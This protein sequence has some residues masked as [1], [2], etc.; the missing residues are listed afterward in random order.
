MDAVIARVNRTS[1]LWQLFAS[2]GDLIVVSRDGRAH[3]Y[4]EVPVDYIH[5]SEFG[6]EESYF[7]ITLEYGPDH[8][9]HDPFDVSVGR[10]KQSDANNAEKGRYLHPVV[11]HF[12]AGTLLSEHHVAENLENDWSGQ[13]THR[14]PLRAFFARE[15]RGPEQRREDGCTHMRGEIPPLTR[16][17]TRAGA[18]A[19]PAIR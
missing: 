2:M 3:Y 6:A 10:I 5:E 13:T 4:E 1:A 8:D 14:E 18:S 19:V 12:S 16:R 11:R 7:V 9:Q 15:L 17:A